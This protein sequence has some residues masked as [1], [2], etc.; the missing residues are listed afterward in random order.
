[1]NL[2]DRVMRYGREY[3]PNGFPMVGQAGYCFQNAQ[4]IA[5]AYDLDY[6][7]GYAQTPFDAYPSSVSTDWNPG[8]VCRHAWVAKGDDAYEVT[9]RVPAIRYIGIR[10]DLPSLNAFGI[11]SWILKDT[12]DFFGCQKIDGGF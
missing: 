2:Y 4:R 12:D 8:E 1:M 10:C 5:R 11:D 9:W 6:V 3:N 7:E